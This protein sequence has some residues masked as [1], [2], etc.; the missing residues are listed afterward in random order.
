ME[1]I[2]TAEASN[3]NDS[4]SAYQAFNP[5]EY[6]SS[7]SVPTRSDPPPIEFFTPPNPPSPPNEQI[8]SPYYS[9]SFLIE[10]TE[11]KQ[12]DTNPFI[13]TMQT[14]DFLTSTPQTQETNLPLS[15]ISPSFMTFE[16]PKEFF[17][18]TENQ[19]QTS[20]NNYLTEPTTQTQSICSF[21]PC[22]NYGN[23]IPI[24]NSNSLFKFRCVCPENYNGILC[25]NFSN[26]QKSNFYLLLINF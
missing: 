13:I 21:D 26:S 23:C 4:I 1:K 14:S 24:T 19:L 16:Y 2:N 8:N 18:N 10:Q 3:Q 25:E 20:N 6:T 22:L 9:N 5:I 7:K 17:M 12:I 11:S 15:T